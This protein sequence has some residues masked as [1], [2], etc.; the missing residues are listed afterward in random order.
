MPT[1]AAS[2]YD[3]LYQSSLWLVKLTERQ[4]AT[5]SFRHEPRSGVV[6]RTDTSDWSCIAVEITLMAGIEIRLERI[7][8]GTLEALD[9][10]DLAGVPVDVGYHCADETAETLLAAKRFN[11]HREVGQALESQ[12]RRLLPRRHS[13]HRFV[14]LASRP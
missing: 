10:R 12:G 7:A 2:K 3:G 9:A 5:A 1:R 14:A 8:F 6:R 4:K 13:E 11:L